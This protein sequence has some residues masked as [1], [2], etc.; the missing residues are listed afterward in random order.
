MCKGP[1]F[2]TFWN[3]A[4]RIWKTLFSLLK[5][6]TMHRIDTVCTC[7]CGTPG[8]CWRSIKGLHRGVFASKL[9]KPC[10]GVRVWLVPISFLSL[11]FHHFFWGVISFHELWQ[12]VSEQCLD[13]DP[14]LW[15]RWTWD[16]SLHSLKMTLFTLVRG[17]VL[18]SG[19]SFVWPI[20]YV[21][22]SMS[23]QHPGKQATGTTWCLLSNE[24]VLNYWPNVWKAAW[25][26]LPASYLGGLFVRLC[27]C[28]WKSI[29]FLSKRCKIDSNVLTWW[30]WRVQQCSP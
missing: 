30:G 8:H 15:V 2:N 1:P 22:D 17:Y 23:H 3:S 9:L 11:F 14:W 16:V 6:R 4:F 19:D 26:M 25:Q 29:D 10:R 5:L 28:R 18:T 12:C 13:F 24:K 20:W 27:V 21:S 7:V